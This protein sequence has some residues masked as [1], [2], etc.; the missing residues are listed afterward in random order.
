MNEILLK[1]LERR[2]ANLPDEQ[3]YRVLD[4]VEFLESK[5]GTG[6]HRSTM[7]DKIADGVE[8]TLR[9]TRVPAA[10]IRGT[11]GAVDSASKLMD[12]LSHA[13]KA[14]VEELGKTLNDM[15]QP[16][17]SASR[18]AATTETEPAP[19]APPEGDAAK[20]SDSATEDTAEG[21]RPSA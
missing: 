10:A 18:S 1:R 20:A 19:P 15:T 17:A 8:D 2:L 16:A 12:K 3:G 5:Y 9:A 6:E 21:P 14:A 11:M 4:F 13:G 7:F